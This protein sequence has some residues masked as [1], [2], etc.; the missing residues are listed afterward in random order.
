MVVGPEAVAL[1]KQDMLAVP[2][3]WSVD[4]PLMQLGLYQKGLSMGETQAIR[5][6]LAQYASVFSTGDHDL[7]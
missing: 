7:G 4:T 1:S 5:D 3:G 6:L 2:G